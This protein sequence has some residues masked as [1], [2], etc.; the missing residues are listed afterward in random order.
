MVTDLIRLARPGHWIKN[1]LVLLPVV[2]A[3]RMRDAGA[4]A[5]AGLAFASFCLAASAVYVINDIRDRVQDRLHPRK[6]GRPL[7]AGRLGLRAAGVEAGVLLAGALALAALTG[8]MVLATVAAYTL[9]QVL[10]TYVLSRKMLVDVICIALGFVLRALAGA[11]AIAVRVSPWLFVCTFT[12]CLFMGF[13]KR[14]GEL[15]T[16]GSGDEG[17]KHRPTLAGYTPELLTHLITL[18]AA[19]A[20]VAYLLYATSP[21]TLRNFGTDYPYLVFSLPLVVYGIFRFAM[22]SMRGRYADP[23]ELI[24]RDWPFQVTVLLWAALA[25]AAIQYGPAIDAAQV[26]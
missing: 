25:V 23:V 19:I 18:S 22:L 6:R 10:Y 20:V 15:A 24:L 8:P 3:L 2:T 14:C 21:S 5:A 9:L 13:C 11:V 1:V 16:L 7:A 4:W 17:R 26:P 12:L